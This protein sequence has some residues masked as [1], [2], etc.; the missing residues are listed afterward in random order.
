[1]S[2]C[3]SYFEGLYILYI[4]VKNDSQSRKV[5]SSKTFYRFFL[6]FTESGKSIDLFTQSIQKSQML[7]AKQ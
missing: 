1:M 6:F 3:V 4:L 5:T 7:L 2:E